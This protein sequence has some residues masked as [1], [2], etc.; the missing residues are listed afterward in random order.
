VK[1]L[2][3]VMQV[4]LALM[5]L[6]LDVLTV[7][8]ALWW[9]PAAP[10]APRAR[11]AVLVPA[12]DEELLLPR[13]LASLAVLDYPRHLFEVHVV[14]DNCTDATARVADAAGAT[15]HQR[16]DREQVSKGS[17]LRLVT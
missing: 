7:A 17:A 14:A 4:P 11:F 9:R 15:V 13:L 10:V 5:A 3:V 6:Y 8:A 2:L 1:L 16:F 12:H